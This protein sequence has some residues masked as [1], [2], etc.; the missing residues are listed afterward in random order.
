MIDGDRCDRR[1]FLTALASLGL[2]ATSGGRLAAVAQ[3]AASANLQRIDMHH[4]FAP[5]AWVAEVK[6]R[7]LL[8]TANTAWTPARSIEDMDRGGVAAA[9]VSITN[10]GLWFGDAAVTRRVARACN[11]YGAKLVQDYPRRFALF[12]AMPLPDVDA[13]LK[14]IAYAYD[15]IKADGVGLMTSYGDTWLGNAAYRPVMEELNRRKAVVHVHPTAANCCRNLDYAPGVAPGS[16]E[17]GTD[18][19]RAIMGVT[20]SGDAARFPDI[21]FIWSHAGGTAPF[22]AGRIDGASRNAK[23]RLPNGFM[24]EL[25]KFHYDLAGAANAGAIAS[26]LQ[27][28]TTSQVLFGTDFPPGGTSLDIARTLSE[29]RLFSESD[30]R[31]IERDNAVRLLPRLAG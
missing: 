22:L 8:Q 29:L 21:R 9:A 16:M 31:A 24:H 30:L 10:P 27:L 17:Y 2:A 1:R 7:P 18:T 3:K 5:P 23:D 25:K 26:L 6:G 20:F 14:E 15:V 13:T 28:V 11:D 4:H 19:T 12:A